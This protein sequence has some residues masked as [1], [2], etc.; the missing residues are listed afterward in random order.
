MYE[1][2]LTDP[3]WQVIK[4]I[5]PEVERKRKH[6]MKN[7]FNAMLYILKSGCHWR[8][9]PGDFLKWQIVYYYFAK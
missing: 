8:M 9:L 4:K 6:D 1:T 5:I 2:N 3:Q 7:I